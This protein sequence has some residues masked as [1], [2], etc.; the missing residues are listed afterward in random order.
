MKTRHLVAAL[1]IST[2]LAPTTAP[3]QNQAIVR[4]VF[5]SDSL[6]VSHA[7]TSPDGKW[8]VMAISRGAS[9]SLWITRTDGGPLLRLTSDGHNDQ[10]PLWFARGDRLVFESNRPN[11]N[12]G[13][14]KYLMTLQIDPSTGQPAGTPRQVSSEPV[15]LSGLPSPDGR[16]LS[17][18]S[19]GSRLEV[20][21][22]P[23]T[24]G[25]A[26][27]LG[28]AGPYPPS[29]SPDSRHVYFQADCPVDACNIEGKKAPVAGGPAEV[30]S[31]S[32]G[33]PIGVITGDP[34]FTIQNAQSLG[35]GMGRVD[36]EIIRTID[37][38]DIGVVDLPPGTVV[39]GPAGDG[40]GI[41]V[42]T[43]EFES[44]IRIVS[45]GGGPI[46][47]L[48]TGG[49][50]WPEAW[51][52]GGDVLITDR[53]ARNVADAWD[54][55]NNGM[56]VELVRLAGGSEK[57]IPLPAGA[58]GSGWNSSLGPWFSYRTGNPS[59]LHAINVTTG[60]TRTITER[61]G[62]IGVSGRGG[63]EQDGGSMVYTEDLRDGV[64][65]KSTDPGTGD[66]KVVR[67]IPRQADAP[68]RW[69]YAVH[70]S[71]LLYFEARR[72][73]VDLVLTTS[74]EATPRRLGTW[75]RG[76]VPPDQGAAWSWKGDRVAI[77]G[78]GGPGN[79]PI[80]MILTLT[81][82]SSGSVGRQDFDL[83]TGDVC[84]WENWQPDDSGIFMVAFAQAGTSRADV[85]HLTLTPGSRPIVLTKDEPYQPSEYLPSPDGK[86]VAYP[87]YVGK[88]SSIYVVD[89][90]PMLKLP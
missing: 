69:G 64:T 82:G 31:R 46:R 28:E 30:L 11:R 37:G 15:R 81:T 21:V 79:R 26:R 88:G 86:Q 18:V 87:V 36:R 89:L 4:K 68:R 3:A 76:E 49:K 6:A 9:S 90:K 35:L 62:R 47:T 1:L 70:G 16:W 48:T 65:I 23:S 44:P 5:T 24:G 71:R 45:A 74:P 13:Q 25:S 39:S 20:K 73:S 80:L 59:A 57:V 17:Y 2:L 85:L 7:Q 66:T 34:R 55:A 52:P 29:F 51:M 27:S 22:V 33:F 58:G 38:R 77:C 19:A 8:L 61:L 84:W 63:M 32:A 54:P 50:N 72:D 14:Q 56:A 43:N 53:P 67:T 60:Q 42:R 75:P 40:L 83:G 12:G 10:R 78:R 41:M